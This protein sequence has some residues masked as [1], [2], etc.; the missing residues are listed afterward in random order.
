MIVGV[1]EVF[2]SIPWKFD[3]FESKGCTDIFEGL[4]TALG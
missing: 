4:E 1:A 3:M 2:L